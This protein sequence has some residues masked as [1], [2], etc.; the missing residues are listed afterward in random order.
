MPA[1]WAYETSSASLNVERGPTLLYIHGGGF[2]H[3]SPGTARRATRK[4]AELTGGRCLAIKYHYCTEQPFPGAL[5]DALMA[6]LSLLSPA[7]TSRHRSV[8]ANK[9]FFAGESSGLSLAMSLIQVLLY[10]QKTNPVVSFHGKKV[11]LGLP[12]GVT[13]L[14]GFFD[15][16]CALPS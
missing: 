14:S 10:A 6:Y 2:L 8:P 9:I 13:G 11:K 12:A 15:V 16:T 5:L 3:G 7:S 4:L 1:E